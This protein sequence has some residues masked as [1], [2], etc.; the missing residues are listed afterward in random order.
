MKETVDKRKESELIDDEQMDNVTGGMKIIV[1]N[2]PKIIQSILRI[3]FN[4]KKRKPHRQCSAESS[5]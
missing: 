2:K 3:I 4:I 5:E 1:I